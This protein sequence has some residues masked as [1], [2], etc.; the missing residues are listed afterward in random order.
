[1]LAIMLLGVS[2]VTGFSSFAFVTENSINEY[3]VKQEVADII[4]KATSSS[5]FS[6]ETISAIEA[7]DD[8]E[9]IIPFT[10]FDIDEG[11]DGVTRVYI[12]PFSDMSF[13]TIDVTTGNSPTAFNQVLAERETTYLE[14]FDL[15]ETYD[16][17][18]SYLGIDFTL[19]VTISGIA[20]NPLY[21]C[22]EGEVALTEDNIFD[23]GSYGDKI[24]S[25]IFYIDYEYISSFPYTDI[26]VKIAGNYTDLFSD[27]YLNKVSTV[28]SNLVEIAGGEA[29]CTALTLEEN[30]SYATISMYTDRV[31]IICAIIFPIFFIAVALLV[32]M[33]SMTRLTDDERSEMAC[34]QTQGFRPT[35]ILM[36]Y[37]IF[38][39][40]CWI[41]GTA[42][43]LPIGMTVLPS[44]IYPA[45]EALF[46]MPT[47]SALVTPTGGIITAVIMLAATILVTCVVASKG[48][49]QSP[50]QMLLPKAPKAGK[51]TLIERIPF[52]WKPLPF[53][54][55]SAFRN[56][57]RY[58]KTLILTII[59][60]LGSTALVFLGLALFDMTAYGEAPGIPAGMADSFAMISIVIIIAAA[61]LCILVIYNITDMNISERKREIAT[62]KVLGY[63]QA[64]VQGYIFRE[65]FIMSTIGAIL[66]VPTGCG[67]FALVL[68]YLEFGDFNLVHWYC[69]VGT[70]VLV[71]AF[72]IITAL[73]LTRK[74]NKVDM[75]TSLKS[76]D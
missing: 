52:I 2:C 63:Q 7:S 22:K 3:L 18:L 29:E 36:K 39:L 13:N 42:I 14:S 68:Y 48:L 66:G 75:T 41:I 67:I 73:L 33:T 54:Y 40:I 4:L 53:R 19:T 60:V 74:I 21:F 65:V 5:G 1:M 25:R 44:V 69:Y 30:M 11:D 10:V 43:G 26:Y 16:I 55:K 24:V 56:I 31:T 37:I 8:V 58:V 20:A 49:R 71:I 47:M 51:K 61:A 38:T 9:A 32:V 62:L 70:F 64:E 28:A 59:S 12:F 27:T 34:L 50:A 72:L 76:I 6:E 23:D 45:Y 17:D 57:F 35:S 15:G 46:Y